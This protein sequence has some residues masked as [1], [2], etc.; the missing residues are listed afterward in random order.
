MADHQ[1]S[2]EQRELMRLFGMLCNGVLSESEAETL[3]QRLATDAEARAA[4][5]D[6]VQVHLVM[7][8][9]VRQAAEHGEEGID[10]GVGG[11][12]GE[13][14]RGL[15]ALLSGW[16]GRTPGSLV[17]ADST[18]GLPQPMHATPRFLLAAASILLAIAAGGYL[19]V[20]SRD[21]GRE[22][23]VAST[24]RGAVGTPRASAGEEMLVVRD[25][26]ALRLV[27]QL[28]RTASLLSLQLPQ[29]HLNGA[30]DLTL[31]SG[32]AWM[33]RGYGE[34]ER[35]YVLEL[36]P[37][38]SLDMY[39]DA[40]AAGQNSLSVIELD[41]RAE[42]SG[43]AVSFNNVSDGQVVKRLATSL[44]NF[45][46]V[47]ASG[48][49]RYF[50]LTG[51]YN[52]P[53]RESGNTWSQSDYRVQYASDGVLVIGWDDSRYVVSKEADQERLGVDRDYNDTRAVIRIASPEERSGRGRP[54]VVY[55]PEPQEHAPLSEDR[56]SGYD[57]DVRPG[58]VLVLV[59]SVAATTP[60]A[61]DISEAN[62]RTALWRLRADARTVD[63]LS[64][65]TMHRVYVVRNH[66]GETRRYTLNGAY[67]AA[68]ASQDGG[69]ARSV[70]TDWTP[71]RL[72]ESEGAATL[73]FRDI[74]EVP[75]N[76]DWQGVSVRAQWFR[77]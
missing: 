7:V 31:C 73:G 16:S 25:A 44:G 70:W 1:N 9:Q 17:P 29:T 59:V 54:S 43:G 64:E 66:S 65:E 52:D 61:I 11:N 3:N 45:Q 47:N 23:A 62:S 14:E 8:E 75:A 48:A 2:S 27:S 46:N 63:E 12:A 26:D 74:S 51:S 28:T 60:T 77:N 18:A 76:V 40:N 71:E 21:S 38:C 49:T 22:R 42:V 6:Y 50:L 10:A 35:G 69:P 15:P 37:G 32:T 67:L 36:P 56:P 57:F 55:S 30:P 68:E 39:V 33:D 58:E 34:Q 24:A 19:W 4:Y 5:R 41:S 72:F 13:R 20:G 53:E